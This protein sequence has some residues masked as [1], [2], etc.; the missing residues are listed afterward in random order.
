MRAVV[1][2]AAKDLRVEERS[3]EAV[4]PGQVVVRIEVGGICGSDLHYFNHGGFGT[5]RLREPMHCSFCLEGLPNHCANMRFYGSAMV[6]PHVQGGF[7]GMLVC[8]AAQCEKATSV[9]TAVLVL[10]EP[11][12]VALHA[13]SRAGSVVGKRV[14]VTGCG[15]IGA[16]VVAAA[17]FHGAGEIVVTDVVDEPLQVA[18]TLG[19]DRT[20]NMATDPNG[21]APFGAGK[22][23]VEVMFECSGNEQA[24]RSGLAVMRP[25][26]IVVQVGLGGEFAVPLNLVVAKELSLQG[27]FRFHCEFALAVKLLEAGKVDLSPLLSQ[28][29]EVD[30]AQ[31][32]FETANDRRRA[33]KVQ[34]AF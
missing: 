21:L 6:M 14:L 16:L 30:Q 22:G 27:T 8:D 33:M 19:A 20:I 18:R 9:S 3:L 25:R 12:S 29:F 13:L 32:A 15:P 24:L 11:F 17:H 23:S 28:T 26:G 7:R 4:G 1:I 5:V 10:A 31:A 2:H 34:L